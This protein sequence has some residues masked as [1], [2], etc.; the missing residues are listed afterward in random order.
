MD[1][2]KQCCDLK[3]I[4]TTMESNKRTISE[5]FHAHRVKSSKSIVYSV[6]S[7]GSV[8]LFT[9]SWE[10]IARVGFFS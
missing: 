2:L 3:L 7:V 9:V 8:Q 10:V 1:L 5:V 6:S 4:I